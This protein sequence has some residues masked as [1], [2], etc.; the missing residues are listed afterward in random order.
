[1]TRSVHCRTQGGDRARNPGRG[2][3]V[4]HQNG[5]YLVPAIFRQPGLELCRID[6]MSSPRNEF[7]LETQP[8]CQVSPE[9]GEVTGL[10]RQH[11]VAGG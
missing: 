4:H 1:M 3:I 6:P 7:D 11:P 9:S 5:L 8:S 10:E 2:F